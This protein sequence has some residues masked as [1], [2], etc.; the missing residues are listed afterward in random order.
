MHLGSTG[1]VTQVQLK[2]LKRPV[3]GLMAGFPCPSF[4]N[5]GKK[6]PQKDPRTL[7]TVAV[8]H[9]AVFLIKFG[10]LLYCLLEN[11]DGDL[12]QVVSQQDGELHGLG[13]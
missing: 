4:S 13:A 9:W 5:Q 1:D 3:N 7:V 8:L 6:K 12:E 11:V 10:G 2:D